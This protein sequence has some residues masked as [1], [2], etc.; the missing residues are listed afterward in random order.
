MPI[1]VVLTFKDGT[2]E[3]HYVPLNLMYGAKPSEGEGE[4]IRYPAQRWTHRDIVVS[5][6][7]SLKEVA[8]IE[9][10]PSM[11][12]ADFD[13]RNNRLEINWQ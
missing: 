12:M 5:S 6:K 7:R 11:R 4:W 10:D 13:R 9:I 3:N 1:E 8:S 2:R